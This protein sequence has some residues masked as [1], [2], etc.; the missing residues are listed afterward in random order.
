MRSTNLTSTIL[1]LHAEIA[2]NGAA[3]RDMVMRGRV[4]FLNVA[5]AKYRAIILTAI[6]LLAY[7]SAITAFNIPTDI[8]AGWEGQTAIK[9]LDEMRRPFLAMK[10]ARNHVFAVGGYSADEEMH[11]AQRAARALLSQ[12]LELA[13]Y[14]P[15][16]EQE[17]RA[18]SGTFETW[19]S[20]QNDLAHYWSGI[21]HVRPKIEAGPK[22][23]ARRSL[24]E[25]VSLMTVVEALFLQTMNK[26][27][28][29]EHP[30]HADIDIGRNAGRLLFALSVVLA[31]YLAGAM[32]FDQRLRARAQKEAYERELKL[33]RLAHF[34][35]LTGLPNR[36]LFNDR[37]VTAMAAA[38][39]DRRRA[40]IL[41]VDLD[42]FKRV[43]DRFGHEAGDR[44]LKEIAKRLSSCVREVDTVARLGGDEFMVLLSNII[45]PADSVRVAKKIIASAGRPFDLGKVPLRI[46]ASVGIAH[47][48]DDGD[49]FED[50]VEAADTAMY[51]VKKN[52]KRSYQLASGLAPAL[53][54]APLTA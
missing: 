28:D 46:G 13:Q 2:K 33:Q 6:G 17:V 35:T 11:S 42:G 25:H 23:E 21:R 12:Y 9:L 36:A 4:S 20:A 26:L 45:D 53:S 22:R 52:G 41:F 7:L 50:L 15:A 54:A 32:F 34:D 18:L 29:V 3:R 40:A 10:A 31:A 38:R 27:G 47:Y 5:P 39:R 49:D 16:L 19:V 24:P 1:Y 43:N 37:L 14:N 44:V 30:L 8:R 48:P 51:E